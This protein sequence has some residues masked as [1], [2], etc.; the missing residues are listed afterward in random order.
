MLQDSGTYL[1]YYN[2]KTNPTLVLSIFIC[3][4]MKLQRLRFN[5]VAYYLEACGINQKSGMQNARPPVSNYWHIIDILE[6]KPSR[7]CHDYLETCAVV[8]T[9]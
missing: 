9:L 5:V 2:G 6:K 3:F 4:K 1:S 8:S 7:K